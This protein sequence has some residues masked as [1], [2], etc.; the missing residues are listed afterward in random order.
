M[1][2]LSFL[3]RKRAN[4]DFCTQQFLSSFAT[5]L[6]VKKDWEKQCGA[7]YGRQNGREENRGAQLAMPSEGED[8]LIVLLISIMET[9]K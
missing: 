2:I 8:R 9:N 7:S 5:M 1:K 6:F 3:P 4:F